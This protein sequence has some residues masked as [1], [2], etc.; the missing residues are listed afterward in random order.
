[1]ELKAAYEPNTK[2]NKA[3]RAPHEVHLRIINQK[4]DFDEKKINSN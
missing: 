4:R 3:N 2:V 1:M